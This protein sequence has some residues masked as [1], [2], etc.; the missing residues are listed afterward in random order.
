MHAQVSGK[1]NLI[2]LEVTVGVGRSVNGNHCKPFVESWLLAAAF[3]GP[4][5]VQGL[6]EQ[7]LRDSGS[8][9]P[10]QAEANSRSDVAQDAGSQSIRVTR[11]GSQPFREGSTE[12]FTGSVRIDRVFRASDPARAAGDLVAFEP[13]ARTAWHMHPLGQTLIVTAGVGH[14]QRWD[15]PIEEIRQG[16]VVWIPP[17]QK[18]WHGAALYSSMAHIAIQGALN[19]KMVELMEK[20]RDEQYRKH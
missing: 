19:G 4:A 11:A 13:G 17:G 15:D 8:V 9:L 6:A 1:S 16:D 18:H 12:N 5:S 7:S 20:V 2:S 3:L 10:N 14:V